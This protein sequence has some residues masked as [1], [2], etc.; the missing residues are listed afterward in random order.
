MPR[1]SRFSQDDLS[2]MTALYLAGQNTKEIARVFSTDGGTVF[3]W[4]KKLGVPVRSISQAKRHYTLP[5]DAFA[6]VT[7]EATAY[8]FGFLCADGCV[9][10]RRGCGEVHLVLAKRDSGHLERFAAFVGTDK[11]V[12]KEARYDTYRVALYSRLMSDN[13]IRLGCPPGKSLTLTF[14]VVTRDLEAHFVRG[15]FDDA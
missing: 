7:D 3:Y 6:E 8:W 5:E 13:L 11:P 14:P 1:A 12:R 10:Q 2:R 15:Y 9:M 4:L